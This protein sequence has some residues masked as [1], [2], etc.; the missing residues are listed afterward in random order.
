[1]P[2][3]IKTHLSPAEVMW[4]L[5]LSATKVA[6]MNPATAAIIHLKISKGTTDRHCNQGQI[7]FLA[8]N[9]VIEL[10]YHTYMSY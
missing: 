7:K 9:E 3:T 4:A 8:T 10:L 2:A 6:D 5:R 1:M